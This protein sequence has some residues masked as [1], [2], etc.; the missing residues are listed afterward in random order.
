VR[1]WGCLCFYY[2]QHPALAAPRI[3]VGWTYPVHLPVL[4]SLH[5][6]SRWGT[7]IVRKLNT[8]GR[9][10]MLVKPK[11][12]PCSRVVVLFWRTSYDADSRYT[13]SN[14]PLYSY[15]SIR[16]SGSF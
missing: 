14:I 10:Q 8:P 16:I 5:Q 11:Q 4:V 3:L 15:Y 9:N 12:F 2:V 1:R 6:A 13:E 7:I